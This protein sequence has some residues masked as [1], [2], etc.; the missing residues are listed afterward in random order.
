MII[1]NDFFEALSE[2]LSNEN[3][4]SDITYAIMQA[5]LT[6]RSIFFEFCFDEKH[7]DI[8]I[9]ER[10]YTEGNS[11]PDFYF[12][13]ISQD[14]REREYVL[15]VKIN[16]PDIHPKYKTKFPNAILSFIANYNAQ[17]KQFNAEKIYKNHVYTW[18]D[19][20]I[21][22]Q[23]KMKENNNNNLIDGYIVY[24][25]KVTQFLEAKSMNLKNTKDLIVFNTL[26][27]KIITNFP[28]NSLEP[29]NNKKS[30]DEKSYGKS[31][32]YKKQK[33][34]IEF[35]MGVYFNDPTSDPYVTIRYK[36]FSRKKGNYFYTLDGDL[37][38]IYLKDDQNKKLNSKGNIEEQEK[39]LFDFLKEFL[40]AI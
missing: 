24:L 35:W 8:E 18:H 21:H 30:H 7:D 29:N 22:L 14:G 23:K 26:L 27:D 25:K 11:R 3:H 15:E 34:R 19:F 38:W 16:D 28:N 1:L 5:D 32:T 39:I 36:D 2:R 9:I 33:R 37:E 31:M 12:K 10:E 6:F 40:D 20:I 13:K 4:L 17:G